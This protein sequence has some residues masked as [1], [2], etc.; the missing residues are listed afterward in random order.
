MTADA[1]VYRRVLR[2]ETHSARTVPAVILAAVL[3]LLLLAA[4]VGGAWLLI[5]QGMRE[6]AATAM[7]DAVSAIDVASTAT[8]T[9]AVLVVIAVI[10]ILCALLPGRR[11]R[12]GR[13]ADRMA[14]LVDDGVL[15]DAT[16]SHVATQCGIDRSQVS[17][18]VGRRSVWVR[19]T[20]TSGLPVDQQIVYDAASEV[21]S[22]A[23]FDAAVKVTIARRGVVS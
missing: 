7:Q 18:T 5:D 22:G 1:L 11:A 2:R 14:V 20:P 21:L 15:A 6:S 12:H 16:A 13:V 4:L 17:A 23:G 19:V 8:I 10:L 3:A 9:G